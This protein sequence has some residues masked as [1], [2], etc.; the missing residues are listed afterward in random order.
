MPPILNLL[1]PK[2]IYRFLPKWEMD[3]LD[4]FGSFSGENMLPD[5]ID[6]MSETVK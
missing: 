2:I 3:I 1:V 4:I 6:R 5:L